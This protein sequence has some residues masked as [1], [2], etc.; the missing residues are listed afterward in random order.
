[1][2][3]LASP[4]FRNILFPALGVWCGILVRW[5]SRNDKHKFKKEDLAVG[6]DIMLLACLIF[7]LN[8]SDCARLLCAPTHQPNVS[9]Q[10]KSLS[11]I[12][13][14]IGLV[15]GLILTSTLVR[16][17][18]WRK[19]DDLHPFW[20]IGLPLAVGAF[21]LYLVVVLGAH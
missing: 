5:L 2:Q 7:T 8:V 9:E 4:L 13:Y 11:N 12:Y 15:I 14:F 18:G 10:I 3:F 20:G 21:W 17:I 19:E 6:F 16:K 1:M